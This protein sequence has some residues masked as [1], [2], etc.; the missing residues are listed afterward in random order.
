MMLSRMADAL[1][2]MA[3]GLE[4]ADNASRLLE[5]NLLHLIETEET[6]VADTQWHPFLDIS[7]SEPLFHQLYGSEP[8]RKEKL[9]FF[10]TQEKANP[11]SIVNVLQQAR[12][13]ARVVRDCISKEMWESV[14][15]MWLWASDQLKTSLPPDRAPAFC[16]RIRN[17][18][19]RFDG[20]T[21]STMMQGES[22]GFYRLGLFLERT[23]MTARILDVKY[24]ILLPDVSQVGSALDY[25]QWMALLK[26]LSGF[27]AFRRLHPAGLRP[28]DVAEFVIL[29]A[30]FPRSIKFCVD[31]MGN[32][33]EQI[34]YDGKASPAY[35]AWKSLHQ[36]LARQTA[37]S[38]FQQGLHEFLADMLK[39]LA[40][41]NG[42]LQTDYFEA[43]LGEKLAL[44]D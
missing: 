22:Y 14:N 8:I 24:Y 10:L 34:G 30:E 44:L 39:Q 18:V 20:L 31:R 21:C 12:E 29:C 1:Y 9:V 5:I 42:A 13:N 26:S 15:H 23:D 43:H 11:N 37:Q 40:Q 7:G 33:L 28:I 41:F 4:R 3:R 17:E 32:A 38:I 2:W 36:L 25:Y 6:N 35:K 19:A 27:E 16:R